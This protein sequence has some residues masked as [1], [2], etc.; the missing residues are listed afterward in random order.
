MIQRKKK[1]C[2]ECGVQNY[3]VGKGLCEVCYRKQLRPIQRTSKPTS[4]K[5]CKISKVSKSQVTRNKKYLELR[6][7]HLE[8]KPLCEAQLPGCSRIATEIH[9]KGGRD[10]ENLFRHFLSVCRGCHETIEMNP[11]MAKEREFTI[12]RLK[13]EE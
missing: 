1:I 13:K 8:E 5:P 9:H 2:K 3:I 7:I 12:S 11:E 10:G 4:R 6:K